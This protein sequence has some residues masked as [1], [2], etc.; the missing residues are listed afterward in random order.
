MINAPGRSILVL[1]GF[2]QEDLLEETREVVRNLAQQVAGVGDVKRR[3]RLVL[4]D[5]DSAIP[6]VHLGLVA[7][8]SVPEAA[9]VTLAD[10]EACLAAHYQDLT[11]RGLLL[12]PVAANVL[13]QTAS[14]FLTDARVNGALNLQALNDMLTQLRLDDLKP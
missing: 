3:L 14:G 2:N 11:D 1:D 12:A 7:K 8:D 6:N 10:V 13:N 9:T 4:V 5:Y